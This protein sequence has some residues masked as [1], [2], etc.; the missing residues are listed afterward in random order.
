M[1]AAVF[2]FCDEK[3]VGCVHVTHSASWWSVSERWIMRVR[4]VQREH[5]VSVQLI[6]MADC[7]SELFRGSRKPSGP[8]K[9]LTKMK[10]QQSLKEVLRK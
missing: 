7:H 1:L 9:H 3:H 6:V 4:S 8:P 2:C 5:E 10:I